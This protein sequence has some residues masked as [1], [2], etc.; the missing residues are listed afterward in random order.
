MMQPA[1]AGIFQGLVAAET[2]RAPGPINRE[3]AN[4]VAQAIYPD[5]R[6]LAFKAF[7]KT[8]LKRGWG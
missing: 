7:G 3:T 1:P 8:R 6:D 2:L 5:T 4:A